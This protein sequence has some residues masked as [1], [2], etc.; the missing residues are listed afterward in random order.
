MFKRLKAVPGKQKKK[1]QEQK[2]NRCA[3]QRDSRKSSGRRKK[4]RKKRT[5]KWNAAIHLE[6][7]NETKQI[8]GNASRPPR[9]SPHTETRT[10]SRTCR[11][12]D[13]AARVSTPYAHEKR[14]NVSNN[15]LSLRIR[16]PHMRTAR[17]LARS[18]V[19]P[20]FFSL[21]AGINIYTARMTHLSNRPT[22][23]RGEKK[24]KNKICL[25]VQL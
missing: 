14:A 10:P 11:W 2:K 4:K 13:F 3:D 19:Q 24:R 18:L 23:A 25:W 1:K 16:H 8:I 17:A 6:K 20:L 12:Q 7:W 9:V 21:L 5:R 22:L 15:R